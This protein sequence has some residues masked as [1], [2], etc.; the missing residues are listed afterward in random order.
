MKIAD[1]T[2]AE[3]LPAIQVYENSGGEA[4]IT[5]MWRY[6]LEDESTDGRKTVLSG[7]CDAIPYLPVD[8]SDYGLSLTENSSILDVGCLGG[9]GLYDIAKR[10]RRDSRPIPR[11]V[12]V[13]IDSD[14]IALSKQLAD[15]WAVDSEVSFDISTAENLSPTIGCFDLVIARLVL[16]YTDVR[17]AMAAISSVLKEGGIVV[18]QVHAPSYYLSQAYHSWSSIKKMIYYIKP[19]LAWMFFCVM[20]RQPKSHY[21]QETA[22]SSRLLVR[23]CRKFGL[24]LLGTSGFSAKPIFVFGAENAE[25]S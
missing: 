15:I 7:R 3:L 20:R 1:S 14:T 2:V 10:L 8:L 22:L 19:V 12:G 16:P 9:Y 5:Q 13:D 21:F 6:A 11:M 23:Q 17:A 25:T 18:L 4:Y 24:K